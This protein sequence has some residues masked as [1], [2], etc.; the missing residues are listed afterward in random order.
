MLIKQLFSIPSKC[1][2]IVLSKWFVINVLFKKQRV[3]HVHL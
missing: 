1:E 2:E 3:K